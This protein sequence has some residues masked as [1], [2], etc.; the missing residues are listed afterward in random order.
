MTDH[1]NKQGSPGRDKKQ[2]GNS[3][4]AKSMPRKHPKKANRMDSDDTDEAGAQG[5]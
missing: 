4:D 1:K 2:S 5:G 3:K